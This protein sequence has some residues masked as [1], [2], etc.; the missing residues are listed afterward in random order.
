[1]RTPLLGGVNRPSADS[2]DRSRSASLARRM[3]SSPALDL[4]G[5]AIE[6]PPSLALQETVAEGIA[7]Q[8]C[9]ST[10]AGSWAKLLPN[11][12]RNAQT[13]ENQR[14]LACTR[15]RPDSPDLQGFS[16]TMHLR[17]PR[18]AYLIE[19][20]FAYDTR[21]SSVVGSPDFRAIW[22]VTDACDSAPFRPVC[23]RSMTTR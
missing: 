19:L 5:D 8:P 2:R 10:R 17:A 3:T 14:V 18:A 7:G 16:G 13:G 12:S 9:D 22:R 15:L 4:L 20:S 21:C 6:P 11:C 1:M 23:L